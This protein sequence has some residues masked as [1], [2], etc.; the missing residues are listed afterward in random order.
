[1]PLAVAALA[2]PFAVSQAAGAPEVD[3]R[4]D[5]TSQT[6][7]FVYDVQVAYTLSRMTVDPTTSARVLV[8]SKLEGTVRRGMAV[9]KSAAGTYGDHMPVGAPKAFVNV[10]DERQSPVCEGTAEYTDR[11]IAVS[12]ALTGTKASLALYGSAGLPRPPCGAELIAGWET[13]KQGTGNWIRVHKSP[14]SF[15]LEAPIG[16]F[17]DLRPKLTAGRDAEVAISRTSPIQQAGVTERADVRLVFKRRADLESKPAPPS[18]KPLV[19]H[20]PVVRT[21][22]YIGVAHFIG[23]RG[24]ETLGLSP[25]KFMCSGRFAGGRPSLEQ[26]P[27]LAGGFFPVNDRLIVLLRR[28]GVGE[29]LARLAQRYEGEGIHWMQCSIASSS[30]YDSCGKTFSGVLKLGYDVNRTLTKP[31]SFVWKCR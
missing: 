18:S 15:W 22:G 29:Q 3:Y 8:E 26:D 11:R 17:Q 25:G 27:R 10:R 12:I 4:A 30:R 23:Y 5:T 28:V 13:G 31:F 9:S 20:G 14:K 2:A 24:G 1:M 16:P 21:S 7:R 19:I 6:K